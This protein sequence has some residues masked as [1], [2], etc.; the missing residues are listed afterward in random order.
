VGWR[1]HS[2]AGR[3]AHPTPWDRSFWMSLHVP[4]AGWS[5]QRIQPEWGTPMCSQARCSGGHLGTHCLSWCLKWGPLVHSRCE[6]QDSEVVLG[7]WESWL[8]WVGSVY[9]EL[10]GK[11]AGFPLTWCL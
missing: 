6:L 10:K 11:V 4:L 9:E 2:C 7:P 1:L 5:Q 3:E 8:H